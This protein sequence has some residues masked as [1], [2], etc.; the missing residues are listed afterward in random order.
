[1]I[2]DF[3]SFVSQLNEG[4]RRGPRGG[5]LLD[6]RKG[7]FDILVLDLSLSTTLRNQSM[8]FKLS[9]LWLCDNN[10]FNFFIYNFHDKIPC[11]KAA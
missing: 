3:D 9:G 1:M 8:L 10:P 7:L 2:T 4:T 5:P 11:H 6:T